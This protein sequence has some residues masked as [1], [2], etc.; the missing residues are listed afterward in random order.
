MDQFSC[1]SQSSL[2]VGRLELDSAG[3][4]ST[5]LESGY[6]F[7][8]KTPREGTAALEILQNSLPSDVVMDTADGFKGELDPSAVLR[9]N[10]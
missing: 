5:Y 8:C 9:H 2:E 10:C 3:L 7:K 6:C 1:I 4:G